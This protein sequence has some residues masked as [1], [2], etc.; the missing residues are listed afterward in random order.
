MLKSSIAN[1]MLTIIITQ[2]IV[3]NNVANTGTNTYR[4]TRVSMLSRITPVFYSSNLYVSFPTGRARTLRVQDS[5]L[6]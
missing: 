5:W 2:I 3:V 4:S 6:N 1:A